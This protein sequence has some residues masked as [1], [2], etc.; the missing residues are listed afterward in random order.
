M[1]KQNV[2][3][4]TI[5]LI[6]SVAILAALFFASNVLGYT[7]TPW[8]VTLD[9]YLHYDDSNE[10]VIIRELR[11]PRALVA[12]L[13][14]A[15]LAV[16][17]ALMQALTKNPMASPGILGINA[18]A[19]FF[20]MIGMIV[21]SL[22]THSGLVWLAF[23]GSAVAAL[24]VYVIG[25]VGM[26]GLTPLK[27]TL[28]GATVAALFSSFTS[29]LMVSNERDLETV[30]FWLVGSVEG[31]KIEHIIPVLP[32]LFPGFICALLLGKAMNVIT[33]GEDV[34]KGLGQNT[35]HVKLMS[36]IAVVLLSG[37][38]VAI[39]GPISFVGL[40]VPH[41]VRRWI[42]LDHRWI[43][44][45]C[46]VFGAILLVAADTSARFIAFPK[47]VPVGVMTATI[48]APFFIY[49]ARKGLRKT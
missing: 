47:E 13:V 23:L 30:L 38:S 35:F 14:G 48:G 22:S 33:V 21:L 3:Y 12:T 2:Y 37:G 7:N 27:L 46:A 36:L 9:A 29:A 42:G 18:G 15:A 8:Q 4:K 41:I 32:F 31:R 5:G 24:A 39:A 10:H 44:P 40:V 25:S 20:I 26:K 17:G 49:L 45:Y 1:I 11:F 34:A 16:S 19:G 6:I 28:A 43:I